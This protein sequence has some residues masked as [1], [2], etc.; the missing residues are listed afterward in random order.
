MVKGENCKIHTF[1]HQIPTSLWF[2]VSSEST[3]S[4]MS[5]DIIL[6]KLR[7]RECHLLYG[8]ACVHIGNLQGV[9]LTRKI[10][11]DLLPTSPT[12]NLQTHYRAT[13]FHISSAQ[14]KE[15]NILFSKDNNHQKTSLIQQVLSYQKHS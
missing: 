12:K 1:S 11:M 9:S 2:K 3:D 8:Q 14:N 7:G 15:A 6:L 4:Q 13:T 5:S 10:L